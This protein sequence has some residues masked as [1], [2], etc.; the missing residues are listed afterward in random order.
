MPSTTN[1]NVEK[2]PEMHKGVQTVQ[3]LEIVK[4]TLHNKLS[5][6]LLD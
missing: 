1:P 4:Q 5:S 6:T 3:D 2:K